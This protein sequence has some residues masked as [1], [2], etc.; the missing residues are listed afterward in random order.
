LVG[1]LVDWWVGCLF[2]GWLV[3]WVV[4]WAVRHS[5]MFTTHRKKKKGAEVFILSFNF[6]R[7]EI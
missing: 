4:G 3:D 2:V 7:Q 6:R 5:G 1:L